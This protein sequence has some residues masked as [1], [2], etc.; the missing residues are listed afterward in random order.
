MKFAI[1]V[2]LPFAGFDGKQ[3]FFTKKYPRRFET[4]KAN[5]KNGN[6]KFFSFIG[7][8]CP[9]QFFYQI[10]FAIF[11][12]DIFQMRNLCTFRVPQRDKRFSTGKILHFR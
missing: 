8:E 7:C 11:S 4:R 9:V 10:R 2:N 5:K 12:V 3:T 6:K 1:C